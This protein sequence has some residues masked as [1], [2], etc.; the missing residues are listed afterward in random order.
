MATCE[1]EGHLMKFSHIGSPTAIFLLLLVSQWL[2]IPE[3]ILAIL[4]AYITSSDFASTETN[5][6]K[7]MFEK[8]VKIVNVIK[9]TAEDVTQKN[10]NIS[11]STKDVNSMKFVPFPMFFHSIQY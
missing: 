2:A 9:V 7:N 3:H 5:A 4:F 6:E 8:Y 11:S 10:A 1:V